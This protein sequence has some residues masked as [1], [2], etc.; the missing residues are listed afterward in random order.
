LIK[1]GAWTDAALALAKH[2]LP[3]WQLRRLVYDEG[4][5]LCSLSRQPNLPDELD[6]TADGCHA[7]PALAIWSAVLDVRR[8]IDERCRNGSVPS[9][10]PVSGQP[11]CCDNFA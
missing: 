7:T 9:I 1:A 4:E 5:W 6:D 11:V 8:R 3:G 10:R 2:E